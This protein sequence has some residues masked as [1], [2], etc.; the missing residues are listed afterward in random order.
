LLEKLKAGLKHAFAVEPPGHEYSEEDKK[1]VDKL[2]N[3]LVKRRLTAPA[4]FIIKSSAPINMIVNQFLVFMK[5]FATF[6]FKPE[7]YARFTE[8]LEHRNSPDF[9]I[10]RIEEAERE[11]MK[12]TNKEKPE[13]EV[14][15]KA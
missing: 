1:V 15:Q 13:K 10:E 8:I 2:A 6:V 3:F 9:I 11:Y 7:E 12:T 14:G 4:I 5:P